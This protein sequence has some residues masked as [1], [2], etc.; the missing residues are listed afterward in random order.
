MY[1]VI[2]KSCHLTTG[3]IAAQTAHIVHL[4]VDEIVRSSY[5][6][7]PVPEYYLKYLTWCTNPIVIVKKATIDELSRLNTE[8]HIKHFYDDVYDKKTNQWYNHLTVIG[9]YP[10][11]AP[12]EH[13]NNFDLL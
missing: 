9:F 3:Q 4:M 6:M 7:Y 8:P 5:E 2:N 11:Y 10:G 12:E 1:L 13:M